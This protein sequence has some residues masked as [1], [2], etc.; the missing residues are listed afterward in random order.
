MATGNSCAGKTWREL[1]ISQYHTLNIGDHRQ[2]IEEWQ[3]LDSSDELAWFD[4]N[5]SRHSTTSQKRWTTPK[6]WTQSNVTNPKTSSNSWQIKHFDSL[7]LCAKTLK[8]KS[9]AYG[10][11]I[12]GPLLIYKCKN[13]H[14]IIFNSVL[15][16]PSDVKRNNSFIA[17]SSQSYLKIQR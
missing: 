5:P 12:V 16:W 14:A 4:I 7:I 13:L 10:S 15:V 17:H 6:E 8:T 1:A 3:I 11:Q 9:V 2:K